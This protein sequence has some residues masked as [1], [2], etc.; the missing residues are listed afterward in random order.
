M[1]NYGRLPLIFEENRGQSDP[2]VKFLSHGNAHSVLFAPSQVQ[3]NLQPAGKASRQSSIRMRF[4]GASRS[5]V[6]TGGELQSAVSSY[7]V[8]HDPSKWVS[9]TPNYRRVRYREL[10]PGVDLVFYGNQGQLEY[11]FVVAPG[12]NPAAIRLNFDGVNSMRLDSDGDLLL[13]TANGEIRQHKPIVYQES[14]GT[15][16]TIAGRYVLRPRHH[17]A[18]QVAR[19]DPHLPLVIDPTLSF[20][21]YLGSPGAEEFGISATATTASYPA[22]AVDVQGNVYLTGYTGDGTSFSGHPQILTSTGP[23]AGGG[24]KVFLVKMNAAG[25]ALFYSVVFGG[26]LTDGGGGVAVD[27]QGNAYVT[28]FTGSTNFPVTTGAPQTANNGSNNAFVTKVNASGT[29]LLYS[30]FLGGSGNFYGRAIGVDHS[31]NAYVTGTAA[32]AGSTPFPVVNPIPGSTAS[33]GF[34]T[35]VNAAGTAFTYSTYLQAG[36]GYGIAVDGSANVYVA[37]STGTV[38][39]PSPAQGYVLKVNAGGTR[40]DYG[41]VLLGHN[42]VSQ[43]VGFGIA[44]DALGS[45][46]VTGM[47]NDPSFPQLKNAAQ[48]TY[49]GGS[50]D[51]FAVKLDSGGNLVYGTYIGG[52]GGNILPERGSGI[53]VDV[54]GNAYVAGTTQ[55]IGFPTTNS[56]SATRN[57]GS[58]VLMHGTVQGV[59][60]EWSPATLAGSF[61]QVTALAFDSNGNLYAGASAVSAAGGG[62]YKLLSG[63]SAW[64]SASS[65]ITSTTI[66]S[67]AVDPNN[68]SAVYA[69]GGGNIYQTFNGGGNWTQLPQGIGSPAVLAVAKTS[70]STIY[71]G[72]PT[73]VMYSTN[74][75]STWNNP[76]IGPSGTINA[77]VVD[78]N[79]SKTAY[80]GTSKGAYMT[81]DA[82]VNWTLVTHLSNGTLGAVTGLAVYSGTNPSTVFAAAS[83]GLFYT[84]NAS[85]GWSPVS[86]APGFTGTP[87]LVA[88]DAAENVYVALPGSG[89]VTA[90]GGG[91]LQSDWS[92]LTYNGLTQNQILALSVPPTGAG[93]YAGIVSAT[94][95]F[96]TEI[97][98]TGAFL[99][100]TCIGGSDNNMGQSIAVTPGFVYVSGLTTATNFPATPSAIQTSNAGLY[101][102]FVMGIYTNTVITSSPAGAS[103]T[104]AGSGCSPG[105]Y[106]APVGL[107]WNAGVSCTVTF[108]DPQNIGG[109]EYEF[110]S[111]TVD[112]SEI[113][114]A[115]P[116]TVNSGNGFVQINATF[117][118]V[119]GTGPG[120]ATHFSVAAPSNATAGTPIQFTVT[121]LDSNNQTATSYTDPVHF[122]STDPAAT[123]PGDGTLTNGVGTFSASLVTEGSITITAGDLLQPLINGT[124]NSITVSLSTAGLRFVSMPPCRVVDTRDNSKPSGFGPP[125]MTGGTSRS[126]AVPNGP[127]AG[128]PGSAQAY[129]LNVTVVPQVELGYLTIWPTG[130]NQPLASTLNSLDGRIKANAAIVPAG[131]GGAVSVFVTDNT[132][133][134][135]DINGYFV[136]ASDSSALAF[137]PMAPCR[138]VD[139][140]PGA[141]STVITGQLAA[142]STTTL[143]ILSST[144][145]V[146]SVAQ[147]YSL[148]FT[149]VPPAPVGYLTVWPTGQSQPTV[150]TLNDLTGT[151][152]ANAAIEPAGTSGD[153]NVF[154]TSATDLVVDINGYFAPPATGGLSLYNLPP[155]RVLDTRTPLGSPPFVGAINVNVQGSGCGGT[156]AVLG[157]VFNAT[158]VPA[159]PLGYLTL[160][161]QGSA[162]PVVSTLNALDGAI[163]SNMAIVPTNNT[164]VSAFATSTTYLILD[165]FGYFGP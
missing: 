18:F 51:A 37:G 120:M 67:I 108:T 87:Q 138:L 142:D 160:W 113:S 83:N 155:C 91:T 98:P 38:L 60:S 134:V 32:P 73:S 124:S 121:A 137:Y 135:L 53:A 17:V 13:G 48:A 55:C 23:E 25:T 154:V 58:A 26:G 61:D 162:Q 143:P 45:A 34:L 99:S 20:A 92:P 46:Y 127:C 140:R 21:T 10:Y 119:T 69:A 74:A 125:S 115:N 63:E 132:D 42:T 76:V 15:R 71:V 136:P 153:I 116:I 112:G 163:T 148:N 44:V 70:P 22:V 33:S 114:H 130:Q 49:G 54:L 7:F 122:T 2:R 77:I 156:G 85:A 12:A 123:L 152:V 157:Y 128:I 109:I 78:P 4:P 14:A 139:T 62:I 6:L 84:T 27:A 8:G 9:G 118:A 57:G 149:L 66:D 80:A 96:L 147:A 165:I 144:C 105:P 93:A 16:Q 161:P 56:I 52:L 106:T 104:V 103:I 95:A 145:N 110:Q 24:S 43:T 86:F 159:G 30:T 65:G 3:L 129:A 39:S 101:D 11:D 141:P 164:D 31:G 82:G 68:A 40:I 19:Y 151:I 5:P 90:T 29:A 28:G 36:I 35:E 111:S 59:T 158:V 81:V 131:S 1:A 88:V 72:T 47:T 100:S 97:S 102:A 126:F 79:S 41:P 89:I 94:T 50:Y 146:P 64:T 75:G 117:S 133:V 150:S 107:T